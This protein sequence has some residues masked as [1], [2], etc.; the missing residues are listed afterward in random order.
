[1]YNSH[2][3]LENVA[4]NFKDGDEMSLSVWIKDKKSQGKYFVKAKG[5]EDAEFVDSQ[6]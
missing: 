6:F 1:M 4:I 3:S 5:L 2:K